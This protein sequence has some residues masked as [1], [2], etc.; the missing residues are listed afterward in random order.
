MSLDNRAKCTTVVPT[1]DRCYLS[2][3]R[4]TLQG[5]G[6]VIDVDIASVTSGDSA[7]SGLPRSFFTAHKSRDTLSKHVS[8]PV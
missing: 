7:T 2:I 4:Y 5:R 6:L 1:S 3:T 8:E